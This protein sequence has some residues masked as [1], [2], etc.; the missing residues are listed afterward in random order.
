MAGCCQLCQEAGGP[1]NC[2]GLEGGV[3]GGPLPEDH[4]EYKFYI[5]HLELS[6]LTSGEKKELE[7]GIKNIFSG[8]SNKIKGVEVTLTQTGS[9]FLETAAAAGL[10]VEVVVKVYFEEEDLGTAKAKAEEVTEEEI[11]ALVQSATGSSSVS[12][13][14]IRFASDTAGGRG[15]P[16]MTNVNGE[17][18]NINRQ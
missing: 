7:D 9:S 8:K 4:A 15:D 1:R 10:T 14:R 18:F 2:P 17:K 16:H 3:H 12:T 6:T 11:T 13:S 5:N